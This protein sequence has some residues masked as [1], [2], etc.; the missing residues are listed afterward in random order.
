MTDKPHSRIPQPGATYRMKGSRKLYKFRTKGGEQSIAKPDEYR[1]DR[2][3][4]SGNYKPGHSSYTKKK[5][6]S[7]R[8]KSGDMVRES[9]VNSFEFTKRL[10]TPF[11]RWSAYDSGVIDEEGNIIVAEE[12][13]TELQSLSFTNF[14][15]LSLRLK[16]LLEHIPGG[17]TRL[18]A[19]AA[20]LMIMKENWQDMSEQEIIHESND[21]FIEYLRLYKLDKYNRALEEMPTVNMGSGNIAGGGVNGPDDV[22]VAKKARKHYKQQNKEDAENYHLG[23]QTYVNQKFNGMF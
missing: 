9:L 19:Y 20:N 7:D 3:T 2:V 22:K 12:D 4:K 10:A 16:K 11:S 18:A 15:V 5:T 23:I 1:L 13:R 6:M 8:L 21:T 17:K 14:D